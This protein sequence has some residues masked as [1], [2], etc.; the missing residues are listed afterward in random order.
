MYTAQA[1]EFLDAIE[2]GWQPLPSGEDGREVMR[3]VEAAYASAEGAK[4]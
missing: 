1:A 2:A 3:I 4:A